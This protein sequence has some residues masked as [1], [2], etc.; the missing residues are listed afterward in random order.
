MATTI[1]GVWVFIDDVP[2]ACTT[3]VTLV[4]FFAYTIRAAMRIHRRFPVEAG[5]SNKNLNPIN[6]SD[7]LSTRTDVA[8]PKSPNEGAAGGGAAGGGGPPRNL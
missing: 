1:G 5:L 7:Y 6:A 8:A 3:S 2:L 4:C